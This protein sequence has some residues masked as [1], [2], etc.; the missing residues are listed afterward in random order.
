MCIS[1]LKFLWI[2]CFIFSAL[3]ILCELILAYLCMIKLGESF[4]FSSHHP[5]FVFYFL[6]TVFSTKSLIIFFLKKEI[7]YFLFFTFLSLSFL[8]SFSHYEMSCR[9]AK[10]WSR[11]CLLINAL[12]FL[13]FFCL[14]IGKWRFRMSSTKFWP[15]SKTWLLIH[16]I[17]LKIFLNIQTILFLLLIMV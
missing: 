11:W 8:L 4:S 1:L 17:R 13:N 12:I 16:I 15:S 9:Q 2:F 10:K 5:I 7:F 14:P 3:G 6:K